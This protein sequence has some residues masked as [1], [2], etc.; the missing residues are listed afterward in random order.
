MNRQPTD[1]AVVRPLHP[2]ELAADV[3]DGPPWE[4][5]VPLG[6]VPPPPVFPIDV[7]P[8]WLADYVRAV[9]TFTQT[10]PAMAGAVALAV[11]STCAGGRLEVEPRPGWRE[12][13]NL[14]LAVVADPGERKSPVHGALTAPLLAA[15][16][17]LAARVGPLARENAALKDIAGR[18]AEQAKTTAAKAPKDK[19]KELTEEAVAAALAA[20]AVTVPNLPRLL[21]DDAT[22]EALTTLMAENGGRIAVISDEGGIFDILAGRFSA[23]PNLDPYLKGHAGRPMRVDRKGREAEFIPTPA[24]TVGVM[25]Q[26]SVL[27]KFGADADL[28]GRGMA[29][30][31]LFVL[32][33]SLA[34][35]RNVNAPPVPP[36]LSDVYAGNIHGL[37][38]TLA[39][40][41]DPVVLTLTPEADQVR[42]AHAERVENELRPGGAYHGMREWANK[43]PGTCLQYTPPSPRDS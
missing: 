12:P 24:L 40:W 19:R 26:P 9:A 2:A 36:A 35:W 39:E 22:P 25:I 21:G 7:Y 43:L 20:E 33:G 17:A 16:A 34:G 30:R 38:A 4:L 18:A 32:P 15:E 13:V 14:F 1:P 42:T 31:F 41:T 5:P 11:L 8:P 37:A 10:D 27:R 3:D 6:T 29:A 23:A 28:T